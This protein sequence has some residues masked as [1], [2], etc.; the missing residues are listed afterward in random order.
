MSRILVVEDD[1]A[2]RHLLG[3]VLK[4]AGHV[5]VTAKDGAGALKEVAGSHFDLMLLDIW[6]PKMNGLEVLARLKDVDASPRIIVM[7]SDDAPETLLHAV[8]EQAYEYVKKPVQP[9]EL[10]ALV[11]EALAAKPEP[12]GIEVVSARPNW[13]ELLVPCD[14]E[15]AARIQGFLAHLDTALPEDVRE[16]VGFAFRE[17]L[18]NA[19]EWGGKL[20]PS[21]KVRIAYLRAR[22]MLLYRI[23]DPG[24][25]FRFEGLVHAAVGQPADQPIAHMEE[26]EKKGLRPG[27]FGI[28]TVRAKVDELL[29]N[30]AQNEVVF[31]KYLD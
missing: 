31:V 21:R 9:A 26:R 15:S 13:V 17:L 5:V 6:M 12:Q 19:I 23:A 29:Y 1:R 10:V 2:T 7:T 3:E 22:R 24:P 8:R 18:L 14:R 30:E 20:D 4:Q 11:G 25:G 16:S 27:G 28:L